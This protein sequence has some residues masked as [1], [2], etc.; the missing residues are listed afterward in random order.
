MTSDRYEQARALLE[1]SEMMESE[2]IT[3]EDYMEGREIN[4]TEGEEA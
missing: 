1:W 3:F 2:V 4:Q